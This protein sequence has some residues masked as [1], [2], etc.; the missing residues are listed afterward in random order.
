MQH[1]YLVHGTLG[2]TPTTED[3]PVLPYTTEMACKANNGQWENA[4]PGPGGRCMRIA[5]VE[6]VEA[7]QSPEP[8]AD[9]AV[10]GAG[11]APPAGDPNGPFM[12]R[13]VFGIPAKYLLIGGAGLAALLLLKK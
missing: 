4:D 3:A 6:T 13:E 9:M 5:P 12:D 10:P 2:S 11:L 7:G 8:T 1:R